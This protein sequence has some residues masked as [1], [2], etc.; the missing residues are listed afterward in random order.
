MYWDLKYVVRLARHSL[1]ADG[2]AASVAPAQLYRKPRF[3]IAR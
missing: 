3:A 2:G 1:A